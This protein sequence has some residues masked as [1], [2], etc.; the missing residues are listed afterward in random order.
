MPPPRAS[1]QG[2]FRRLSAQLHLDALSAA[3]DV[4]IDDLEALSDIR[5]T[6]AIHVYAAREGGQGVHARGR[7]EGGR[8]EGAEGVYDAA[9][10]ASLIMHSEGAGCGAS[11]LHL[12]L[13]ELNESVRRGALPQGASLSARL[14]RAVIAG[15]TLGEEVGLFVA[16][17]QETM[18]WRGWIDGTYSLQDALVAPPG[19]TLTFFNDFGPSDAFEP[20]Q[21]Q[22]QLEREAAFLRW[23][24]YLYGGANDP[25]TQI[26]LTPP[27]RT[28]FADPARARAALTRLCQRLFGAPPLDWFPI[29]ARSCELEGVVFILPATATRARRRHHLSLKGRRRGGRAAT[30]EL[31]PA[32]ASFC[33]VVADCERDPLIEDSA[34]VRGAP[35]EEIRAALGR[36]FEGLRATPQRLE[37]IIAAHGPTLKR[38]ALESPQH[39]MG[40]IHAL[41]MQTSEGL[42]SLG[43][44]RAHYAHLYYTSDVEGF[45]RLAPIAAHQGL[46]LVLASA[47]ED[48]PLLTLA[49]AQLGLALHH[50]DG[51]RFK[52]RFEP[53]ISPDPLWPQATAAWAAA[54]LAPLGVHVT[55]RRFAPVEAMALFAVE[56]EWLGGA[57]YLNGRN[58]RVEATL[59][60]VEA[61]RVASDE[62][63]RTL[64][65]IYLQTL[66][67]SHRPLSPAARAILRDDWPA[68]LR[69]EPPS[70]TRPG[71]P[72]VAEQ[73]AP[74]RPPPF[75][76]EAPSRPPPPPFDRE[77]PSRPPPL[78][79]DREAPSRP[80]PLPFDREAP[81]RPPRPPGAR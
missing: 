32:W 79:F 22:A 23:P 69:G 57:L 62:L 10:R 9:P 39:L 40:L 76:R 41:P 27:W 72:R 25:P 63:E 44:Y 17:G 80:P 13:A 74:S 43:A 35:R 73:R 58:P 14:A 59:R 47:P 37:P 64:R 2:D 30:A 53:P 8:V 21:I 55:L 50:L 34:Q 42:M 54:A 71:A 15:F 67:L 31:L 24:L 48:E 65:L 1:L 36:F 11:A 78:P 56:A 77:A 66:L 51:D 20:P 12:L 26:N 7:V 29:E 19:L 3:L 70:S 68:C 33:Y 46:A 45:Y 38:M 16:N 60:E 4:A 61:G 52:A 5:L 28:T 49:A 75:D 81:S 6:G 18:A